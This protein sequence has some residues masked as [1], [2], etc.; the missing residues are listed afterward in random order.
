MSMASKY[1]STG[2]LIPVGSS[3]NGN[4]SSPGYTARPCP[5]QS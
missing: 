2:V 4:G 3:T 5:Y 1:G